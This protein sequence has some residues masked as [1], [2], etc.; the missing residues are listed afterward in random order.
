LF[1]LFPAICVESFTLAVVM[2]L[3]AYWGGFA[4]GTII[5]VAAAAGLLLDARAADLGR[6]QG[7]I[8]VS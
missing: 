5:R 7:P 6:L 1:A 4:A 2:L 8:G 3:P